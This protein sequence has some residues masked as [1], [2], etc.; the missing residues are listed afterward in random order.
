M[1]YGKTSKARGSRRAYSRTRSAGGG[2]RRGG[3]AR[4][5][6]TRKSARPQ[7]IRIELVHKA[8]TPV[9]VDP[10]LPVPP[11]TF[12]DKKGKARL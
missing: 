11:S 4:R 2:A 9:A 3:S 7:T 8:E 1:P 12:T 6:V 5:S 10:T